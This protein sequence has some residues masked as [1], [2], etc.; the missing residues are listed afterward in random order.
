VFDSLQPSPDLGAPPAAISLDPALVT[1]VA[2][3]TVKV[4]AEA[5]DRIQDGSGAVVGDGLV[6]TN[7]H[8]VAGAEE[9]VVVRGDDGER[10]DAAVVAFDPD[11]DLA[12]LSAPDVDRPA[13]PITDI[14]IRGEG[15]V[16]GYPAGGPLDV[17]PFVV[18]DEVRA[19]G[20]DIYDRRPTVRDVLV[21]SA[22]LAPGDS[23][24]ALVNGRGEVVGVAFAIAPDRSDVAYALTAEEVESVLAGNLGSEVDPGACLG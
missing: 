3:S 5:C 20:T 11:R 13:L 24:A 4:E 21:L 12:V 15:A 8:V 9:V 10:I 2:A 23:G 22:R 17:S 6:A 1:Q 7:A 14:E 19:R 16:F 18:G